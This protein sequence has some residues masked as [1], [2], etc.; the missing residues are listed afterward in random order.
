MTKSH[1]HTCTDGPLVD[2]PRPWFVVPGKVLDVM[3]LASI[4][5]VISDVRD[6]TLVPEGEADDSAFVF[7][8]HAIFTC[9]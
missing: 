2:D 4:L 3:R 5:L 8:S 7:Y 9:S 1:L 6:W